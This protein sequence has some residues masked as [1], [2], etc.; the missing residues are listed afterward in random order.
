M[1]KKQN[2]NNNHSRHLGRSTGIHIPNLITK[3]IV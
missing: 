3:I 1:K 2:N